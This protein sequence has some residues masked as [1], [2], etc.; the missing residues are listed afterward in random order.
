M[1]DAIVEQAAGQFVEVAPLLI[2][3]LSE[4]GGIAVLRPQQES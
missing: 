4:G 1:T 3:Q 2:Q